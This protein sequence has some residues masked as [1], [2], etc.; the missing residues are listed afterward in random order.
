MNGLTKDMESIFL[1]FD[2]FKF[3]FF[4]DKILRQ[5]MFQFVKL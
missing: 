5:I 4:S 1:F 3:D 2:K